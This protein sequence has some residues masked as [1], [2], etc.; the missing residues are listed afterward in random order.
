MSDSPRHQDIIYINNCLATFYSS[1]LKWM[2]ETF[3]PDFKSKIIATY[4]RAIQRLNT[5]IS[6][7]DNP[8]LD[9]ILPTIILDPSGDINV[10][11][12]TEGLWKYQNLAPAFGGKLYEPIYQDDEVQITPVFN[13]FVGSFDVTMLLRSIYEYLDMRIYSLQYFKG[14]NRYSRPI[15]VNS[16]V[17][18]PEIF[19]DLEYVDIN[20]QPRQLDWANTNIS[21]QLI[22]NINQNKMVVPVNLTP[23]VK[24]TGQGDNSTKISGTDL[25]N[26]SITLSF[27]WEIDLPVYLWVESDY[28]LSVPP[29]IN[30]FG[31]YAG[32]TFTFPNDYHMDYVDFANKPIYFKFNKAFMIEVDSTNLNDINNNGINVDFNIQS[33][34]GVIVVVNGSELELDK[35]YI[36][37]VNNN[38]IIFKDLNIVLEDIIEFAV[39]D[40]LE[41]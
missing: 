7:S 28:K 41:Q 29:S 27:E 25:E 9:T 34:Y 19:L 22:I 35:H 31:G 40:L 24:L 11:E 15:I 30:M 18:I 39:Y 5:D 6:S 17:A 13:R 37:D 3:Y 21:E 20:N 12:K 2:S 10:E 36:I 32:R 4:D 26:Y 38:K 23:I 1:F 33:K 8:N 16:F 14:L